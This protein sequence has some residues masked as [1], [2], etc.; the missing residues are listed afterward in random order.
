MHRQPIN[1]TPRRLPHLAILGVMLAAALQMA[2]APA[3]C[4]GAYSER[5]LTNGDAAAS[6]APPMPA[7]SG[8]GIR[9][10]QGAAGIYVE[11]TLLSE[12]GCGNVFLSVFD[13]AGQFLWRGST[14][15]VDSGYS[16]YRFLVPPLTGAASYTFTVR[17]AEG[18]AATAYGVSVGRFALRKADCSSVG[19][20]LQFD[21]EPDREHEIQWSPRPGGMWQ[22]VTNMT[23]VASIT[24]VFV[25]FGGSVS[26]AA[27]FFRAVLK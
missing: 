8:D 24:S 10:Y 14:N 15:V 12:D 22:S 3:V 27:G 5:P 11:F 4:S 7:C 16:L 23:A 19:V 17:D 18:N 2:A 6:A 21:T 9:A 13:E 20:A 25:P 1:V 26:S